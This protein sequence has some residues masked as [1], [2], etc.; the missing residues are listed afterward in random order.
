MKR[1][2]SHE[3]NSI[4]WR[5]KFVSSKETKFVSFSEDCED[6]SKPQMLPKCFSS[7]KI[8]VCEEILSAWRRKKKIGE[9]IFLF[10]MKCD[11]ISH[12]ERFDSQKFLFCFSIFHDILKPVLVVSFF[13]WKDEKK[14]SLFQ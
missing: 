13:L 8:V 5:T 9:E 2:F 10:H 3:C 1:Y 4:T 7:Q 6:N 11:S 12:G 14:N